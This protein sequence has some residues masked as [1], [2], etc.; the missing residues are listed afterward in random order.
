[1]NRIK[2]LI[3]RPEHP[4]IWALVDIIGLT[5]RQIFKR[6]GVSEQTTAHMLAGYDPSPDA[7][8]RL[9]ALLDQSFDELSAN[10]PKPIKWR[11]QRDKTFETPI[12][13]IEYKRATYAVLR[14]MIDVYRQPN[15][16]RRT[17]LTTTLLAQLGTAGERR[18]IV[19]T[20]MR[21]QGHT[22]FSVRRCARR[23]GVR[24]RID[25][26][27]RIFWLPP[28]NLTSIAPKL[29]PPAVV[30]AKTK[31]GAALRGRLVSLVEKGKADGVP[32][33]EVVATLKKEGFT[34]ASIYRAARDAGVIRETGGFGKDKRSVWFMQYMREDQ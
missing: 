6:S 21:G 12:E 29:P 7:I 27:G 26:R 25:D 34:P 16:P 10:Q 32:G 11:P 18:S 4:L 24:S 30:P 31:A 8:R 15:K 14:W 17:E 5:R 13:F 23:I 2:K 20:K 33:A 1:M 9:H 3:P 28:S 22:S 19:I